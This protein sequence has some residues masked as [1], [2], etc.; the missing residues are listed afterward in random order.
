[1]YRF[2][3]VLAY[4]PEVV[5]N[6]VYEMANIQT[7]ITYSESSAITTTTPANHIPKILEQQH[8]INT[9]VSTNPNGRHMSNFF[10]QNEVSM[11]NELLKI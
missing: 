9:H 5:E 2:V 8:F 10:R 6:E 1:M 11:A 4:I 3:Q 7:I